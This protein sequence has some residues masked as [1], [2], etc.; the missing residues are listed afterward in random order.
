MYYIY[1]YIALKYVTYAML[2]FQTMPRGLF[3]VNNISISIPE[4]IYAFFIPLKLYCLLKYILPRKTH[5]RIIDFEQYHENKIQVH[6]NSE[7][8]FNRNLKKNP[9]ILGYFYY[10]NIDFYKAYCVTKI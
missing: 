10:N 6:E 5:L 7:S 8:N 4:C 3:L 9:E 2:P 1:E